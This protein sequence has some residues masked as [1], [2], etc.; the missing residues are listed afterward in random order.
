MAIVD[1]IHDLTKKLTGQDGIGSNITEAINDLTTKWTQMNGTGEN[2]E[3]AITTLRINDTGGDSGIKFP[4]FNIGLTPEECTC[5]M[6]FQDLKAVY[7]AEKHDDIY[8]PCLVYAPNSDP[9]SY[10]GLTTWYSS[11]DTDLP[12]GITEAFGVH[13]YYY[14]T[15][16]RF[17]EQG[18]R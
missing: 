17:H 16:N 6:T 1:K 18:S 13:S 12:D 2:I 3:A 14:G 10:W 9:P 8:Y 11:D 5:D 7:D 15:D 4:T